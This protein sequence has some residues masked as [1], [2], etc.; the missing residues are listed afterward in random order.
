MKLWLTPILLL[1]CLSILHA[2]DITGIWRGYFYS[3][4][5]IYRQVYRYEVQI[6]QINK[7]TSDRSPLEGVT[8]SYHT[9]DYYGKARF[10]GIYSSVT[11]DITLTEDTLLAEKQ[12]NQSFSCLMTCYLQYKKEGN[13]EILEGTFSSISMQDQS[14]CGPGIVRLEKVRESDFGKENFLTRK[15]VPP[16]N[17]RRPETKKASLPSDSSSVQRLQVLLGIPADGI[18]GPKTIQALKRRIPDFRGTSLNGVEAGL[19]ID[20]IQK[21]SSR[22][23]IASHL[24]K[25]AGQSAK[26]EIQPTGDSADIQAN[27][28]PTLLQRIDK[29]PPVPAFL[30]ERKNNLVQ[31]ITT[32]SP[33]INIDLYDNGEID[34]D[35]VTV[36]HNNELLVDDQGL[37]DKP[38]SLKVVA[39]SLHRVHE[40]VLVAN[41]LGKIPPNTA[42]M[43]LT[44]GNKRYE[45]NLVSDKKEN[46]KVVIEYTGNQK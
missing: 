36:F 4:V 26:T 34:G 19:L 1:S 45:I 3:G 6:D 12:M 35:S 22:E 9:T 27:G 13:T 29:L 11:R 31:T 5:G 7:K 15:T 33:V 18:A 38:I 8:Y 44:T 43:V 42:L 10:H 23:N 14:D 46:A 20:R 41:N 16:I 30:T 25:P 32:T 37:T 2:Q 40:F 21:M 24:P 17:F 28:A 39:D